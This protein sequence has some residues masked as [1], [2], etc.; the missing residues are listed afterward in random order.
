MCLRRRRRRSSSS[1][2]LPDGQLGR[3]SS[4]G[5]FGRRSLQRKL[6]PPARADAIEFLPAQ[7]HRVYFCFLGQLA[8]R[9]W[10]TVAGRPAGRLAAESAA[11][12][13][14][15]AIRRRAG[16]QA[17]RERAAQGRC[18]ERSLN[19]PK[20]I[21]KVDLQLGAAP[22]PSP[23]RS[24]ASAAPLGAA[25]NAGRR[26]AMLAQRAS[27]QA[28]EPASQC[29]SDSS[30]SSSANEMRCHGLNSGRRRSSN[31][32]EV[33]LLR[34]SVWLTRSLLNP[35]HSFF[36]RHSHKRSDG[37]LEDD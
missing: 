12:A 21:L 30:S 16:R 20:V 24:P 18:Q 22:L 36:H 28:S 35:L 34:A 10:F 25:L 37:R 11:V 13:P 1:R 31:F 9:I 7:V 8:T 6:R 5:R 32:A 19:S 27:E 4:G 15:A 33:L 14:A 29:S 17:G 2:S 23:A 3:G 26:N